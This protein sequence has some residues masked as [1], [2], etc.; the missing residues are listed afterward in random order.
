[1]D[2][3]NWSL[4]LLGLNGATGLTLKMCVYTLHLIPDC[5][6]L[7][8]STFVQMYISLTEKIRLLDRPVKANEY[9][10]ANGPLFCACLLCQVGTLI[11]TCYFTPL[12]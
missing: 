2:A 8:N 1:M 3:L 7:K 11:C 12:V 9:I 10:H 6:Y 5:G 4:W